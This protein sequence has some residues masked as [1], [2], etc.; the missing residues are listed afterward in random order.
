MSRA[1]LL[2]QAMP[3]R[4]RARAAQAG[5]SLVLLLWAP[6]L[7]A[8][9]GVAAGAAAPVAVVADASHWL[10]RI[11]GAAANRSYQ[12]TVVFSTGGVVSSSRVAHLCEG[13][14][15]YERIEVLDGRA[16]TQY[17]HNEQ[18]LTLWP[19][20]KVAVL[21]Q[22]DP[23][24]DFPGLP[25]GAGQRALD[26]YDLQAVGSDRVAG[27]MADVL[28]LKPRD[29]LRF[30]QRWWAERSTGLLLRSDVLGAK[31]EVL[32]SSSFVD[33]S[34]DT[35][36]SS[37]SVLSA[38]KKLEGWRV[39]RPQAQRTQLDAEGWTLARPVPGFQLVSCSWRP[40]DAAGDGPANQPVL[41]SVFSDGLTHV[42]VFIEPYDGKRH[43]QAMRSSQG[44]TQTLMNRHGDWWVTVIGEVPLTTAQQF[45]AALE[46]KH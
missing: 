6:W 26:S 19:A 16:H 42:S 22:R 28:M 20:D 44:A 10:T 11:Q 45:D 2:G 43:K 7:Q 36:L 15:R 46:R 40:L 12:G 17:R 27:L 39:V 5:R 38:M 14:Q 3:G 32:E 13:R 9:D 41:Q 33:L 29:A 21:E 18:L 4:L 31:G 1:L 37:D 8:A 35:K 30:A 25:S 23:I 34:L 24:I